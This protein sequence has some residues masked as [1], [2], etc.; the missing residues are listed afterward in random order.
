MC[1]DVA[2]VGSGPAGLVLA[3]QL[4][5]FANLKVMIF[6]E[7][8]GKLE[9]GQADGIQC[10]SV[11]MFQ[12][13]GFAEE[14]LREA[15]WVN[16]ATFWT[17]SSSNEANIARM[18]R[19]RDTEA[20]L[21]EFPHVILS[22]A[23][24]HDFLLH[25]AASG[26]GALQPIYS[27]KF[28]GYE[29]SEDSDYP[30][31][32]SLHGPKHD[33]VFCKYLVGSDGA[34]SAVRKSMGLS[35]QGESAHVAW[36]VMDFL[37]DTN[38]P[39]IRLKSA[40]RS[41]EHGSVLIIPREGES[42]VRFYIEMATL[43]DDERAVTS[44][45]LILHSQADRAFTSAELIE[46]AKKILSPYTLDVKVVYWWSIYEVGQRLCPQF[47]NV[48]I[49][50]GERTPSVFLMGDACHTHSP[51]AGQGMNVSMQDAF[52][53][54]WKLA[55]VLLGRS[56]SSLLASY[57]AERYAVAK[58][59]I[60]F[61]REFAKVFSS[62]AATSP[63]I[64]LFVKGGRF[65]AGVA[66]NYDP[67]LLAP[68][69]ASDTTL[70]SGFPIGDRF[71]SAQVLRVA[72]AKPVHLGHTMP[73]DGRWRLVVFAGAWEAD[74]QKLALRKF[75]KALERICSRFTPR[76]LPI[77]S[78]VDFRFVFSSHRETL[79]DEQLPDIMTPRT[80]AGLALKDYTKLFTD[81]ASYNHGHGRM[82]EKRRV[83]PKRGAVIVVRPDQYVLSVLHVEETAKL[84]SLLEEVLLPQF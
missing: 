58:A 14:V 57:S 35:L 77:D 2:I 28:L 24:I 3:A 6:E 1:T 5:K 51:K 30:L 36:G 55:A 65:T 76:H 70:A 79:H 62:K 12:A 39:D 41:A 13:F 29:E 18:R 46:R 26:P 52:N 32:V 66:T 19:V 44:G 59:L 73:A 38:F 17:P 82:Y 33:Q 20:E 49:H 9:M 80:A 40:I 69:N 37:P 63:A 48:N 4:A 15:Y 27:H 16:E 78:V 8:D 10:R 31:K 72:D 84:E 68:R 42:L 50:R 45:F 22:Q 60:D 56:S 83:D 54:G 75:C 25:V 47:D 74:D 64:Q 7:R 34:R 11:E 23:R 67:R 43:K 53:L 61:D 81:D 71:H 21:S